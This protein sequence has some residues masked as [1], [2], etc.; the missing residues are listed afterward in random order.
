MLLVAGTP[1]SIG[2]SINDDFAAMRDS[3]FKV[4]NRGPKFGVAGTAKP[5][6][7]G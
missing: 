4:R 6:T 7:W 3:A 2:T 5:I 1:W